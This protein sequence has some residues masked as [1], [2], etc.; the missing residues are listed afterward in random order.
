MIRD[1]SL[2]INKNHYYVVEP[3]LSMV[4]KI[5]ANHQYL[6]GTERYRTEI[7]RIYQLSIP[8][9]IFTWI[10]KASTPVDPGIFSAKN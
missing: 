1:R 7:I 6:R 8:A 5:W 3:E 9:S 4:Q 2:D 10:Q